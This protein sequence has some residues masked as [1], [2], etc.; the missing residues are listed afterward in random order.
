MGGA[1]GS[2]KSAVVHGSEEKYKQQDKPNANNAGGASSSGARAPQ[3]EEAH[4]ANEMRPCDRCGE[5][6]RTMRFGGKDAQWLCVACQLSSDAPPQPQGRRPREPQVPDNRLPRINQNL[7]SMTDA[8]AAMSGGVEEPKSPAYLRRSRTA[9][10]LSGT[11]AD[12][13]GTPQQPRAA[14]A[15]RESNS[16]A[17][18]EAAKEAEAPAPKKL[19]RA[20]TDANLGSKEKGAEKAPK[21]ETQHVRDN[22]QGLKGLQ[23]A[24]KA[25]RPLG[26]KQ[27]PGIVPED[28]ASGTGQSGEVEPPMVLSKAADGQELPG[29]FRYGD[30][31]KSL[32]FRMRGGVQ[33]LEMGHE[34]TIVGLGPP[35]ASPQPGSDSR[36]L[37]QF[38]LGFDWLLAANQICYSASFSMVKSTGLPG[39]YK[40]GDQV[41][42]LVTHISPLKQGAGIRLGDAGTIVGPGHVHGKVAVRFDGAGCEWNLW[43]NTICHKE[44]YN[45]AVAE[46]LPGEFSRGDRVKCLGRSGA[47]AQAAITLEAGDEGIIIGPGHATG[48]VL[49]TFDTSGSTWSVAPEQLQHLEA[50]DN[51]KE[52]GQTNAPL[53]QW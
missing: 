14:R 45:S 8:A 24:V 18:T 42:N 43:P 4:S 36:L 34:G 50:T 28:S 46:K 39:G 21:I 32:V 2:A 52:V 19:L 26:P 6:R 31:V 13:V 40:W 47:G 5:M 11:G 23:S 37:V 22:I 27:R 30:K 3:I 48:L 29:G 16:G 20:K 51:A 49:V 9:G 7:P 44:A 53:T 1:A 10:A 25:A 17:V 15:R 38:H 41:C 35:P 33:V 12:S